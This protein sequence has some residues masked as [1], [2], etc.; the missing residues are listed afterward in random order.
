MHL[1]F[2]GILICPLSV[3]NG[4]PP[5]EWGPSF[6]KA[7]QERG[8]SAFSE[9]SKILNPCKLVPGAGLE[10]A[11]R[12]A[13]RD[14]K[15]LSI[16]FGQLWCSR[17]GVFLKVGNRVGNVRI[18][19]KKKGLRF[20]L[21]PCF[22]YGSGE[23]IRTTDLRVMR[24]KGY[25]YHTFHNLPK[26]W[27]CK[28]FRELTSSLTL[29]LFTLK[30]I[31]KVGNRVGIFQPRKPKGE[32]MKRH[33]TNYP[34]VFYREADRIGGKG[35][36]KVFYILFKKDGKIL[37]EKVGR[38]FVDDMTP[39]RAA[40]IR[41]ERIEGKRPSRKEIKEEREAQEHALKEAEANRWTITRLW[42][43]YKRG[44][45]GLK[46]I[47]TDENRFEKHIKPIFGDKQPHELVPLDVDRLRVKMLKTH[48]PA[49][50]RNTLELLRRIINF[51]VRKQ[52]CPG[53][54]FT[55]QMPEVHNERTEDLTP[56]EL[57]RLLKALEEEPN[58]QAAHF[59]KMVLYTGMRRGELFKLRWTDI[60]FDRG[61]ISIR[62]PKGKR[63]Q[64][65]PLSESARGIL[66]NHPR[67]DSP[68][69][70]PGRKG[71]QRTDIHKTVNR[72]KKAAGLPKGFRALHGLRHV[73]ASMLA[74]SG[75]V[76]LYTLQRLLTHKSPTMTQ[77]YAH[78]RDSALRSAS[79]LAGEIITGIMD[80]KQ[81]EKIGIA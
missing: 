12:Q 28:P 1:L 62:D 15:S 80:A 8:K 17:G 81:A 43:E 24:T 75:Q 31:V 20:S 64:V 52:L 16:T 7:G 67:T 58:T 39:A 27:L 53:L 29:P 33:K 61:F 70:F 60:D 19:Q 13:P 25:I 5:C 54:T 44:T 48:K 41:A 34:G 65:I 55:I 23:W 32:A 46:G 11:R 4:M 9:L 47:V 2:A 14:F 56:D 38:Q 3:P 51:G 18:I 37:E 76:D 49:T 40:G 74:S 79:N 30:C 78:L 68:F 77:R 36:E 10:P 22:S 35:A 6:Q 26:T 66:A 63:N 21:S 71:A 42:E 73:Y 57:G 50:V 59:M 45:P 69:V 72:I